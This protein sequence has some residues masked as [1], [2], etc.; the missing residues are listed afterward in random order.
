MQFFHFLAGLVVYFVALYVDY[1]LLRYLWKPIYIVGLFL[2]LITYM[3]GEVRSG[4]ARWINLVFISIQPSELAKI[5]LVI[6]IASFV[7]YYHVSLNKPKRLA[8][9]GALLVPLFFLVFIQ[10]D[11]GTTLTLIAVTLGMLFFT[12]LNKL[13]YLVLFIIGGISSAPVWNLLQDYQKNRILVFLN[14]QMD[15]LGSGYNVIQSL[16]AVGSGG[17][18]GK[19]FSHGTQTHLNFLPAHWTDFIFASFA[20]EWGF[21]GVLV[22]LVLY[23]A[24]LLTLLYMV[25]RVKDN[26]GMLLCAGVFFVFFVQFVINVGMNLGLMP[27][28]GL[29][30][31]LV[32][33]GGSS[34]LVSMCLLGI[35]QSVWVRNT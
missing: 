7:S 12:N 29:P 10:P 14:P 4:S 13:Y 25:F 28:T 34:L 21:V 30:L 11:L 6:F 8:F 35:A 26:F 33:Y 31:P 18:L 27:V 3:L 16:I 32:S 2:L 15:V 5:V 23:M 20:E 17:W 9:L 19:G 24:L 22:F 1:K